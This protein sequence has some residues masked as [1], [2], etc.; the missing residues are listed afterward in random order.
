MCEVNWTLLL[1]YL[2]IFL[3]W[4]PIALAIALVFFSRFRLAIQSL[5]NRVVEGNVLGQTFKAAPP[6]EQREVAGATAD[7]LTQAVE[8]Q[9]AQH[10]NPNAPANVALPPEL[11]SD[12]QAQAAVAWVQAHPGQT[13]AEYKRLLFSYNSERL[14]NAIYG[15]QISLLEHLASRPTESLSLAELTP[16]HDAHQNI[17]G[18]TE[19]QLR[20]YIGFLVNFGVVTVE[21][22]PDNQRY[23]ISQHG[24]EFLSYIKA[25]YPVAW[26]QRAF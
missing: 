8:A 24:L 11:Q 6:L 2:K 20:D 12:P 4:P 26:S 7:R 25:S 9:N 3:G 21:G 5:L 19:Y 1:E 13:V 23:R 10:P 18:R 17:V 15:T 22:A 16:F 14:F